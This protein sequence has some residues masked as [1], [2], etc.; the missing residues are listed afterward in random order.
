MDTF[1][2]TGDRDYKSEKL[3]PKP[4]EFGNFYIN[5]LD[6]ELKV[7]WVVSPVRSQGALLPDWFSTPNAQRKINKQKA[8]K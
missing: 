6:E 5:Y 2:T 7:C 3:V 4:H 1:L 8:N